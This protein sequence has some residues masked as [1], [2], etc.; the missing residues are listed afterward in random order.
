MRA[1]GFYYLRKNFQKC[2]EKCGLWEQQIT[3]HLFI[4]IEYILLRVRLL[5]TLILL[6]VVYSQLLPYRQIALPN[7]CSATSPITIWVLTIVG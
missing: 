7:S 4:R 1:P 3:N 5:L 2:R 6:G